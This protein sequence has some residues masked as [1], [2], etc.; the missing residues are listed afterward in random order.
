MFN[1]KTI[2]N[3]IP[4]NKIEKKN[5]IDVLN[6]LCKK[7]NSK[8]SNIISSGSGAKSAVNFIFFLYSIFFLFD[9]QQ[10]IYAKQALF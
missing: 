8:C 7:L 2:E 4:V 3:D 9:I 10:H 6:N 5:K 1:D